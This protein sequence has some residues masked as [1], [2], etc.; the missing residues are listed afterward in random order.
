MTA[1]LLSHR[2]EHESRARHPDGLIHLRWSD[3][4]LLIGVL[5]GML[6]LV[7]FL[8]LAYLA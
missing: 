7:A 1:H 3:F 6:A 5:G 2:E 8:F 4:W